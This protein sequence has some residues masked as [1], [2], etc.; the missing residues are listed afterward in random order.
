MS[1]GGGDVS[2]YIVRDME[3]YIMRVHMLKKLRIIY[4]EAILF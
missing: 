2:L 4:G 3:G 1:H